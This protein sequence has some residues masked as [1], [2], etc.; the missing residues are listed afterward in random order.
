MEELT[1]SELLDYY[2]GYSEDDQE[3]KWNDLIDIEMSKSMAYNEIKR[4]TEEYR[5]KHK[6]KEKV[7]LLENLSTKYAQNINE[8]IHTCILINNRYE[9]IN[10]FTNELSNF[11]FTTF[12][13]E[14]FQ[15]KEGIIS[16]LFELNQIWEND[17]EKL[18]H[19]T[20]F[21]DNYSQQ[22]YRSDLE[23]TN[24]IVTRNSTIIFKFTAELG[25]LYLKSIISECRSSD[26]VFYPIFACQEIDYSLLNQFLIYFNVAKYKDTILW[27]LFINEND[28]CCRNELIVNN[29]QSFDQKLQKLNCFHFDP[30]RFSIIAKQNDGKWQFEGLLGEI[31]Y[32][33]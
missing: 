13:P 18:R 24:T 27:I 4:R 3:K 5:K 15:L 8:Q 19:D 22:Y 26:I 9:E 32:H 1:F 6:V 10:T 25:E 12:H 7:F 33:Y 21:R 30:I 31:N 2:L 16:K 11:S 17:P 23:L 29:I 14:L 20:K 28:S